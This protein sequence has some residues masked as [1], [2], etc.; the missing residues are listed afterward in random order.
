M[1]PNPADQ[2]D[3]EQTNRPTWRSWILQ[4]LSG[5]FLILTL[6]LFL[7]NEPAASWLPVNIHS[8]L[9]ADYS[10]DPHGH[11]FGEVNFSV[12]RDFIAEM[13]D[14]TTLT[15]TANTDQR[16]ENI[17]NDMRTP[18]PTVT[19]MPGGTVFL[20]TARPTGST[21]PSLPTG[22]SS[23]AEPTQRPSATPTLPGTGTATL[24]SPTVV[25]AGPT[26]TSRP[27]TQPPAPTRT[28]RPA[29][30]NT[31]APPPTQVPTQTLPPTP[32]PTQ[33]PPPTPKPTKPPYPPP[34]P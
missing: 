11:P 5:L 1:I 24:A 34:Y 31:S 25:M 30:T 6:T 22:E 17:V 4:G 9:A 26:A 15:G 27:P 12:I 19:P 20:P 10:Q 8:V 21:T 29:A 28:R 32:R 18:V 7:L 13:A 33:P 2:D 16:Y 14:R 23:T 3:R